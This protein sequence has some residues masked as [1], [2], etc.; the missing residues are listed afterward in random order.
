MAAQNPI[1]ESPA[2]AAQASGAQNSEWND[3][4]IQAY[5]AL[6][7]RHSEL[8]AATTQAYQRLSSQPEEALRLF[9]SVRAGWVDY[10]RDSESFLSQR[11]AWGQEQIA[12][13]RGQALEMEMT[14]LQ[15]EGHADQSLGRLPEAQALF[16]QALS[17][18][19]EA[20]GDQPSRE[21]ASL[22]MSL[23]LIKAS[24]S[25][26]S[27]QNAGGAEETPYDAAYRE[28]LAVE[29]WPTAVQAATGAANWLNYYGRRDAF[30]RRLDAAIQLAETH[31]L[32]DAVRALRF[33]RL[34]VRAADDATGE[35]LQEIKQDTERLEALA[36]NHASELIDIKILA[37]GASLAQKD[38]DTAEELLLDALMLAQ[39]VP[40]KQCDVQS[41]CGGF[42]ETRGRLKPAMEHY[43]AALSL[44]QASGDAAQ[45]AGALYPLVPLRAKINDATQQTQ[46]QEELETLR[47]TGETSYLASALLLRAVVYM[48]Q[49]KFAQAL[50]DSMEAA[51]CAPTTEL[52]RTAL[53]DKMAA[54]Y[55]MGQTEA[56]LEAAL[57]AIA[58]LDAPG[59][60]DDQAPPEEW[61]DHLINVETLHTSAA[62]LCA[63]LGRAREAF[64]WAE[65]GK[66][67]SLRR[68]LAQTASKQ[69]QENKQGNKEEKQESKADV[70]AAQ[71]A[72]PALDALRA[73]L[74]ADAATL[75]MFCVIRWGTLALIVQS[76]QPDP[77]AFFLD[78]PASELTRLLISSSE[79]SELWTDVIFG[80]V[81]TLS[82]KLLHP[83]QQTLQAA[84]ADCP[85]LYIVPDVS[86]YRIPFAALTF[87][88]GTPLVAHVAPTHVPSAA[89]LGWCRSRRHS[90]PGH[91]CLAVGVGSAGGFSFAE[92]ARSVAALG[93][94]GQQFLPEATRQAFL[95]QAPR[96][97]V[98][99]L[100][101]HGGIEETI[102]DTLLACSLKF[103]DGDLTAKDIFA[104]DG[105]LRAELVFLSACQ[106]GHFRSNTRSEVDGFWRAFLHAG[107]ASLIAA[108]TFVHPEY[109]G[110]LA[111]AFYQEW[112]KGGITKAESLRRVQLRMYQQ[113]IEP[114]HWAPYLLIGDAM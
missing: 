67:Q 113:G 80:A 72:A 94:T 68:Q 34:Q 54:L 15:G 105:G 27:P 63:K 60:P 108:L 35:A 36:A 18:L 101:C 84:A 100:A 91:S 79:S 40:E 50:A 28:C 52:R 81:P 65:S 64:T 47:S 3:A 41:E 109:A 92:Q 43:Q 12:A 31:G 69:G 70:A 20:R 13:S 71:S 106:S 6:A 42:Y 74:A 2:S 24:A 107:A 98:L 83:L 53:A 82:E 62:W 77:L 57:E 104:L 16:E 78:L 26:Q 87:A 93:W 11:G 32:T 46:A 97:S 23:A 89:I 76:E 48:T 17:V 75:A 103:A 33:R 49:Q 110:Q 95:S 112:L 58:L 30:M 14:L 73:W 114:R 8:E 102:L 19:A 51:Q 29:L 66:A 56:A 55:E 96:F 5:Q 39:S 44:A 4:A 1:P 9:G 22:L 45:I 25:T 90:Q 59:P 88:D 99:H 111:P 7:A 10:R 21:R 86:L 37:S 38:P 85:T 61:Q